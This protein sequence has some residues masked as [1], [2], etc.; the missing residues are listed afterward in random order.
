[1]RHFVDFSLLRRNHNYCLLWLGQSISFFGTMITRVALPYQIYH[2]THSTLMIGLLSTCQLLPLLVTALYGGVLADRYH[3]R[4]LML[5][6]ETLLAICCLL[7]IL[8]CLSPTPHIGIIFL[9]ATIMSALTGLHRPALE[10]IT[11]QVLVK[12]DYAAASSLSSSTKS[13]SAIAGPALT[14]L[15]IVHFG[16]ITTFTIDLA[17]FLFSLIALWLMHNIPK[18]IASTTESTWLFLKQGVRY[19]FSRQELKGTYFVDFIAMVFGMPIALFPA[20]SQTLGGDTIL[21]FL[22]AAPAVGALL[23]S[24]MSGW[25]QR[26]QRHGI[27]I[28]IAAALWGIFIIGFGFTKNLPLALFFL[29]LAGAA[30]AISG[31]FRDIVWNTVIPTELFGRLSGI[32]MISYLSG[33]R[34]GDAEAGLVAAMFGIT[35]SVVS[36]GILCVIGVGVCCWM[37][38]KFWRYRHTV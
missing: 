7:L 16:L 36:G 34:L 13:I 32:N 19:A 18:P 21:G 22:Y 3:R 25:T 31:I 6:A 2:L 23:I 11:Q 12:K 29:A 24:F 20:M 17:T 37:L 1:M 10:S 27:A 5:I 14:G 28:A 9:L 35:A 38:P 15:F 30:D 8:N 26:M 4:R 33:P